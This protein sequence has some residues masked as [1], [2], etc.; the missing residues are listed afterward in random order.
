[1]LKILTRRIEAKTKEFIGRNQFGFRKGC[2]TRDGIGVMRMLCER[3]LE[4]DN[5]VYICFIDF[6]KAF[7]RV[8]WIKM[9]EILKKL[10]IG[11]KD[12]RLVQELYMHQ[13]VV[14]RVADGDSEPGSI[15]RGVRQGCPLSP[16]LFSIYSQMIMDEAMNDVQEGIKVGGQ[17]IKD[18]RFADDQGVVAHTELGL[19]RL[20]GSINESAKIYGMKINIKKTKTMVVSKSGG[21]PVNITLEG[22]LVEQV[23]QFKYLG[24]VITEDGKCEVEVKTRIA[25]A[26]TAFSRRKELL[27]KRMNRRVRKRLVKTIVWPILMYGCE[28]WTLRKEEI[29]RLEA[30]EMWC[31]RRMEKISYTEKKSNEEVLLLVEEERNLVETI[32]KRKKGWIG[33]VLRGESMMRDVMEGKMEGK[34]VRGRKRIGML[35]ELLDGGTYADMKK[36]ARDRRGWR[37]WLPRT[38]QSWAEHQK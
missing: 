27:T 36:R 33:H 16:L 25:L 19:Q 10:Q 2:G 6:E 8:N 15:G 12:R 23:K 5:K 35:N 7:D 29:R 20:V 26:K 32:V 9:M 30:F 13:E 17:W 21:E 22:Q 28:T 14:I 31:W 3:S 4:N 18:V 37:E 34:R 38:C 24:S 11:W 1:M